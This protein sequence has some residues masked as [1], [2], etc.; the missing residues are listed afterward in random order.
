[1]PN[2]ITATVPQIWAKSMLKNF[3][4]SIGMLQL[5][6]R[7]YE[8]EFANYGD[9]I[10]V[11][12]MGDMSVG[13]YHINSSIT[14]QDITTTD[15]TM[16]L[17][18]SPYIAFRLDDIESAVS[19]ANLAMKALERARSALEIHIDSHLLG[20]TAGFT[21]TI[22]SSA[23][24]IALSGIN[25]INAFRDAGL[26]LDDANVQEGGRVAVV[27]PVV[28]DM[29]ARYADSKNVDSSLSN[30]AKAQPYR[31]IAGFK[32]YKTT[33]IAKVGSGATEHYVIPA[34]IEKLTLSHALRLNPKR[35]EKFRAENSFGDAM[36]MLAFYG[37]KVFEPT[38]G[39]RLFIRTTV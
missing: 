12:R 34:F 20:V 4:K 2:N 9:T 10:H 8:S 17:N 18:Q 28:F 3:D 27:P 35:V 13:T 1:M 31:E 14:F 25:V 36:K 5:T 15:D 23:S 33:N 22:G 37:S 19:H 11:P 38:T 30:I 7:S 21:H 39:V 24:P 32:L 26:K 29:L 6:D 16:V